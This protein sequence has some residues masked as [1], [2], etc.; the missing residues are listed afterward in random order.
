[1]E[2]RGG[3]RSVCI[4]YKK[5]Y[6]SKAKRVGKGDTKMETLRNKDIDETMAMLFLFS[7]NM[8]VYFFIFI[9]CCFSSFEHFIILHFKPTTVDGAKK[10]V[11]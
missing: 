11:T 3:E 8:V 10:A 1:M 9:H 2:E 7:T 4:F 5:K 6:R